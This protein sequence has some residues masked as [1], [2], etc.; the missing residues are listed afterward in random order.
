MKRLLSFVLALYA[1]GTITSCSKSS[2][3]TGLSKSDSLLTSHTWVYYEY[4][5]NFSNPATSLAWKTNRS[6]NTLNLALNQ[7]KYNADNTYTEIDQNGNTLTGTWTFLNNE[8]QV[9][10]I[11]SQ[12]TFTST[13]QLLTSQRYEWFEDAI[14]HYGIMVPKNQA[15]DTTGGRLQLITSHPWVYQEYFTNFNLTAP[16]LVWK[17]NKSNSTFNLSLNVVK[18]NTDGTY[19]ETDE[20]GNTYTGTWTFLNNQ[21]QVRV[22]NSKGTFTSTIKLLST[23]RYEWLDVAGNT[24]GEMIPQ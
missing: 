20:N 21:T 4:F 1:L 11:N 13:I 14:S 7:V 9:R 22:I 24:Y 23:D 10:V 2:P 19:R 18:Y 3:G 6:S 17:T 12:G 16:S 5:Y 15:I 8:T